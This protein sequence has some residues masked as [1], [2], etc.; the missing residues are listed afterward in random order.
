[1]KKYNTIIFVPHARARFRKLTISTRVLGLAAAGVAAVLVAAVAFGWAFL[2]SS[3]TDRRYQQTLEE[4][5]RLRSSE[6][7]LHQRIDGISRQLSEFEARTKRL[8]IVAGLTDSVAGGVGGPGATRTR[9]S[10]T[11]ARG[12]RPAWDDSRSSSRAARP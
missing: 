2:A 3:R 9:A 11:R 5:Q 1:M 10:R 4:N 12:S 7:S 8:A 6:A